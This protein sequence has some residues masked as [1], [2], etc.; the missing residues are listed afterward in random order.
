MQVNVWSSL[1]CSKQM[2]GIS[3]E[4]MDRKENTYLYKNKVPIPT[5]GMVDDLLNISK[6]GHESLINNV[7][8]NT[9]NEAKKLNFNQSKCHKIHIGAKSKGNILGSKVCPELKVHG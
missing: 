6:C 3:E 2:N 8:Q 1:K 9:K 7:T 5:L 4:L